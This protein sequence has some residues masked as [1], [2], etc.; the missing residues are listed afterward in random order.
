MLCS[1]AAYARCLL[2][3]CLCLAQRLTE[4]VREGKAEI[5]EGFTKGKVKAFGYGGG[6]CSACPL[7]PHAACRC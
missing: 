6:I 7:P 5:S 1:T 3:V 4:A 2:I